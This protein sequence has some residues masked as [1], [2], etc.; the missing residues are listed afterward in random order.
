ML[1]SGDVFGLTGGETRRLQSDSL[2]VYP[3]IVPLTRVVLPT[4]SPM[5]T[6]RHHQPI[7]EDPSRI[8]GKREYVSGDS[9][10]RVDWK[11]TAS[12]GHLQVKLFEPSIALETVI[13]LDLPARIC[14]AG[15]ARRRLAHGGGQHD[16]IGVYD[17]I[18]WDFIHYILRYRRAMA[19]RVHALIAEHARTADVTVLRSRRA[20]RRYLVRARQTAKTRALPGR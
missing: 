17:R 15:V 20:A 4:Q 13:F 19:P 11:S 10:R 1:Y 16:T 6:L 5:G 7:F 14:L 18:T 3:K 2:T 8:F 12:T 9:L